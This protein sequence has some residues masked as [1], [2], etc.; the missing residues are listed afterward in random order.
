MGVEE[1]RVLIV[2]PVY[3]HAATLREVAERSLALHPDVLV[4]DDG[5]SDGGAGRLEGLP[6]RMVRHDENRGKGAAILT[7]AAEAERLGMT[8]IVTIDADGQHDPAD[9]ARFLPL[10]REDPW[11]IV[12]GNRDMGGEH[13]PGAS[14]FGRSFSNFWLRVQTGQSLGDTQSGF[15]AY[16]V[17]VL[18]ALS[19]GE[20]RYSFEVEVL[21]KAAWAGV[22]LREVAIS[23]YYPPAGERVSHFDKFLD[24]VRIS[25]L[26]TRLT[27]RS[28]APW[29]HRKIVRDRR[30]GDEVSVLRP[31]QSVR[32]LLTEKSSAGELAAA[33]ALGV[34]LGALPLLAVHT[35]VILLASGFLRLNKVASVGASQLCMPPLVPALCIEAGY[36]MRHG[37]FLTEISME[38]LGYQGLERLY[39]WLL[40]SLLLGPALAVLVGAIVYLLA[41]MVK[42]EKR[43]AT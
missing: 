14:R 4:V 24:N 6:V 8:H 23:V 34:F 16:P 12:V 33:A 26:N 21:V 41:L 39:E 15:R 18:S 1:L 3:N 7:A 35:V 11:A 20:A 2:I 31:L 42:R 29:P 28:V 25:L 19:L 22:A 5:S 30:P 17:A 10:L 38:T 40:G 32:T 43:A 13:V 27:L 9:F 37:E 36:Y